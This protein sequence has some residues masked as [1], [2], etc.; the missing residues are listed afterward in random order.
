MTKHFI[1][2]LFLLSSINNLLGMEDRKIKVTNNLTGFIKIEYLSN[3]AP[4]IFA[5]SATITENSIATELPLKTPTTTNQSYKRVS[6]ILENETLTTE[7]LLENKIILIFPQ[8][9]Q[10]RVE[11][12]LTPDTREITVQQLDKQIILSQA[13]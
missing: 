8:A 3:Q 13:K 7:P 4:I 6:F 10:K 5:S 12:P 2:F 9:S 1:A 11:V